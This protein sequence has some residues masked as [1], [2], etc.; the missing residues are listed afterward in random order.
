MRG[1]SQLNGLISSYIT[2]I[3]GSSKYFILGIV[4]YSKRAKE[5]LLKIPETILRTYSPVS[6]NIT[7]L[8]AENVRRI[9]DVDIGVGITG[10]AG[11][12]GGTL[13][14]PRGTV[15][16]AVS[17]KGHITAKK[18]LLKGSRVVVK[19]KAVEQALRLLHE[20]LT[21]SQCGMRGAECVKIKRIP[22]SA[23]R[24]TRR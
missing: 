20:A 22:H 7:G 16:I 8:M 17:F 19:R 10:Y 6:E 23:N 14:N 4:A 18:Y 2:D 5:R 15:Y 12:K 9:A 1:F 21:A 3:P 11:P 13:R 24:T